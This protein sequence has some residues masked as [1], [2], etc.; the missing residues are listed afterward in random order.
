[1][2]KNGIALLITLFFIS[3]IS[4]IILKN[5]SDS[6]SFI[7]EVAFDSS[8]SQ[9][10]LT[11][12]NLKDEIINL[13]FRYK[14]NIDQLLEI[15]SLGVPLSYG[16]MNLSITLDEYFIPN[17]YLNDINTTE[18]LNEKCDETIVENIAYQYDF[19]ETLRQYKPIKNQ[20]QLNYF[21]NIYKQKTKDDKISLI[22][23]NFGYIAPDIND[24]KRYIKCNCDLN[25]YSLNSSSEFIFEINS[26]KIVSF[27][28]TLN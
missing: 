23:E 13:V 8:L 22:N 28:F 7:E 5:L 10:K 6:E 1:M 24:T 18:Q 9:L 20:N 27:E 2:R 17:C 15:T 11:N 25:T 16:D 19:I 12:K 21:L 14:E 3:T 26:K 4:I